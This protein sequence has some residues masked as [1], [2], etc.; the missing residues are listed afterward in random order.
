MSKIQTPNSKAKSKKNK[1]QTDTKTEEKM[2]SDGEQI[3]N[4]EVVITQ[5]S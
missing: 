4:T 3:S 5:E 1:L 2:E